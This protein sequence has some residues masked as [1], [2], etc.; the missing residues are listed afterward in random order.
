MTDSPN[1]LQQVAWRAEL[2]EQLLAIGTALSGSHSLG[3]SDPA[4]EPRNYPE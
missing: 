4:K 2:V 3:E 1:D